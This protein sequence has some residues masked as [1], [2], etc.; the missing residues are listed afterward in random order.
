[1]G[2]PVRQMRVSAPG[3]VTLGK[4]E[5]LAEPWLPHLQ[6]GVQS[7]PP[8][9][10]ARQLRRDPWVERAQG[11]GGAVE[12][13]RIISPLNSSSHPGSSG[14]WLCWLRGGCEVP[15]VGLIQ[16]KQE[17]KSVLLRDGH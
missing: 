4:L 14:P 16:R 9:R 15:S 3:C 1:M 6:N 8:E 7:M 5:N 12:A 17:Q 2:F 11:N 13:G 10:D